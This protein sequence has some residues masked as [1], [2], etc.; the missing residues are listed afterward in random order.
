[1]DSERAL[2]ASGGHSSLLLRLL[3]E[4]TIALL[5][6]HTLCIT[7]PR[8]TQRS[9][10]DINLRDLR[11]HFK[12]AVCSQMDLFSYEELIFHFVTH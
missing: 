10:S 2:E 8:H 1:M 12:L 6:F 3:S 7:P 5:L 9:I 4:N 11:R